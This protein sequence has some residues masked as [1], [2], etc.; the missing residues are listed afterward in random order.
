MMP[1][2]PISP[3][4]HYIISTSKTPA[5]AISWT[6]SLCLC[7]FFCNG[8]NNRT[9]RWTS[10]SNTS[11]NLGPQFPSLLYSLF[12]RQW[13]ETFA[14]LFLHSTISFWMALIFIFLTK[15]CENWCP[16]ITTISAI[17]PL[18]SKAK[19]TACQNISLGNL[20]S[21]VIFCTALRNL[22]VHSSPGRDFKVV[23]VLCVFQCL[24]EPPN[25]GLQPLLCSVN[26]TFGYKRLKNSRPNR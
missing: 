5:P 10:S 25:A 23:H 8:L 16:A 11:S 17:C 19:F 12:D 13:D 9:M 6:L 21:H 4:R 26:W 15:G 3:E 1:S 18:C 24:L 14:S 22:L 2:M 20:A 7:L